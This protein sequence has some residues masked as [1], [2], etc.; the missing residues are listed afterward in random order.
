MNAPQ[1]AGLLIA[2]VALGIQLGSAA[3]VEAVALSDRVVIGD[4]GSL[5]S[6]RRLIFNQSLTE[7]DETL[8]VRLTGTFPGVVLDLLES[9]G[10]LKSAVRGQV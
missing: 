5:G 3:I 10:V 8:S 1:Y 7:V 4:T 2:A 9:P 6:P